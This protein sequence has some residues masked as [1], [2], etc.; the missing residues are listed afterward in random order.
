MLW[1]DVPAF[2]RFTLLYKLLNIIVHKIC[3]KIGGKVKKKFIL[4][5]L[6]ISLLFG[7]QFPLVF[8]GNQKISERD[9]YDSINLYKPYFYEFYKDEPTVDEKTVALLVEAIKNYYRSRGYFHAVV[10]HAKKNGI[11]LFHISEEAPILIAAVA[12][13]SKLDITGQIS[14]EVG[15]IFDSSQFTQSKQDAKLLYANNSYCNAELNAKAWVDIETNSAYLLYDA[16][17]NEKCYFGA[18]QINSSKNIDAEI[19]KSLLY[20][21]EKELFSPLKITKS[22]ESLYGYEGISKAII[23]T[24]VEANNS[25]KTIVSVSENEKPIRFQSGVGVSSD[26]G[27]MASLGINHRNLYG[28][29]KTAGLSTRVTQL[30]QT[31]KANFDMPIENRSSVG[32]EL[33]FENEKFIGFKERR[34]FAEFH[35]KQRM[36]PHNFKE[37]LLFDSSQTYESEDKE[38]FTEGNL[39]VLSP[40][41]EWGYDVRDKILDPMQGYFI[42]SEV[43]GS[44]MSEVSDATYYKF[45]LSGGY[46]LPLNSQT[47]ALKASLGSLHLIQGDIP[48]SYLF[49]AGGMYSNRAYGYRKLSPLSD[50]GEP[51]GSDSILDTTIEYRFPIYGAFKGVI[52][53]DNTYIGEK[54]VPDY[55]NG[56]FS[57][58][59]GIRYM[60]PIGA[61][62]IDL[63]FDIAN[64][65]AQYAIHFHVGELF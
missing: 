16:L 13:I 5:T 41:L 40:K 8:Q 50:S 44:L 17:A 37:S 11:I 12:I 1:S 62:A 9:L 59:V 61:V 34:I 3:Q 54:A 42:N 22:Y 15:D 53:N 63:G 21:K 52:F 39:F 6:C 36:N 43:M 38:L 2:N 30:K 32:T 60:T 35:L 7:E 29:L 45:K 48:E 25:V 20:I 57:A 19:I 31:I 55:D 33:G 51:I 65:S 26:E 27:A 23:D 4:F 24:T 18:T 64:P 49:Y 28:N 14:F 47:L 46:I 56:Y 10:S 58:G